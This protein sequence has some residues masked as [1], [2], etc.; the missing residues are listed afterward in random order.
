MY[1]SIARD[2]GSQSRRNWNLS[3]S[4][5]TDEDLSPDHNACAADYY[6]AGVEQRAPKWVPARVRL[7]SQ[8]RGDFPIGHSSVA[9]A[10][11]H[12]CTCNKWGAVSVRAGNGKMLGLRP[13][14]FD[15]VAWK[16]NEKA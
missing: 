3:M 11:D 15:V 12:D 9:E 10:G 1:L 13:A 16:A 7:A 5:A 14:E 6:R 2:R 4:N 8:V